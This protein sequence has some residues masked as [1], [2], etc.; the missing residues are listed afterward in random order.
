MHEPWFYMWN[1]FCP[2]GM[3]GDE[4]L[5]HYFETFSFR[6]LRMRPKDIMD[7]LPHPLPRSELRLAFAE[8]M[9]QKAEAAGRI[10]YGEKTPSDTDYLPAIYRD[11]PDAKVIIM[12]RDPRSTA[13]STRH[14]VWGSQVD[15]ANA[16][17]Y[18]IGR[19]KADDFR[20]R[21]LFVKLENLRLNPESEMRRVLDFVD[22]PWDDAV[23]DHAK[24][25]PWP[26][27]MPPVPWLKTAEEPLI[28]TETHLPNMDP[29]RVR[30]IEIICR[31]SMKR[32]GY[33]KMKL[34]DP[35][36]NAAVYAHMASE[37]PEALRYVWTAMRIF[38]KLRKPEQWG[39]PSAY[40]RMFFGLNP[41]W[42]D[43]NVNLQIP[44]PPEWPEEK[45][46]PP[47]RS[48]VS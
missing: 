41:Q 25:N 32:F 43:D 33:E 20:N 2:A 40:V 35:P 15:L 1:S 21:V 27:D 44:L 11:F 24:N 36:S 31:K 39:K 7:A 26:G 16:I 17:A 38:T 12:I 48:K 14:M 4:F 34:Q 22:E 23:L 5:T 6:W 10:R 28:P 9:R 13:D 42:W 3:S 29:M 46:Y 30:L 47:A 45:V 8:M 19:R 18:E 37:L